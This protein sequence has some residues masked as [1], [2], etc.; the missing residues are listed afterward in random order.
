MTNSETE[1][2]GWLEISIEAEP[3]ILEPLSAFLF[4]LGSSGIASEN[5]EEKRLFAYIPLPADQE[6]IR[7]RIEFFLSE[8]SVIFP[9]ISRPILEIGRIQDQDWNSNWK[10][11]FKPKE[12]TPELLILP[13]WEQVPDNYKKRIIRMD[14][15]PAFGTGQHSTTS[16]CLRAMELVRRKEGWNML[17]VGTGSGILAIYGAMLGASAVKAIDIDPEALRWAERN[18]G[19]NDV[20]GSIALS[21]DSLYDIRKKY[22]VVAANLILS[23]IERMFHYLHRVTAPGGSI[24]LSGVLREQEATVEGLC[25]DYNLVK[26][27]NLYDQEWVCLIRERQP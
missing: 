15:G 10:R 20:A 13:A 7:R 5:L 24:I 11:F 12:V 25:G 27:Q 1:H 8:L 26:A 3:T 14:P 22:S 19:L 2:P 17:D 9:D 4:E 21:S 16:M 18:I 6:D 23:E